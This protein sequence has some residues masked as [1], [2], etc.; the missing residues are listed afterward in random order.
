MS[1]LTRFLE[2]NI[3]QIAGLGYE[4]QRQER[5][6]IDFISQRLANFGKAHKLIWQAAVDRIDEEDSAVEVRNK[7][8]RWVEEIS[9]QLDNQWGTNL[10]DCPPDFRQLQSDLMEVQLGVDL[11]RFVHQY[12]VEQVV[13]K[14]EDVGGAKPRGEGFEERRVYFRWLSWNWIISD[15]NLRTEN[16]RKNLNLQ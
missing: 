11:S 5:P 4:A 7:F 15:A 14:P 13:I 6:L 12:L 2:G 10:E 16:S 3:R 8:Y 9:D 1:A